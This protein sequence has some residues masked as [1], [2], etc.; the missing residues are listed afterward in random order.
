MHSH[1]AKTAKAQRP[2]PADCFTKWRA[3]HSHV[4]D[5]KTALAHQKDIRIFQT[6]HV[7]YGHRAVPV[8]CRVPCRVVFRLR[9]SLRARKEETGE[10]HFGSALHSALGSPHG[11]SSKA[12]GLQVISSRRREARFANP[13][14]HRSTFAHF[15]PQQ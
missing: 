10:A 4:L 7:A 8:R 1:Y 3:A 15:S 11:E 14:K 2:I 12:R 6:P 9:C 5:F 13:L